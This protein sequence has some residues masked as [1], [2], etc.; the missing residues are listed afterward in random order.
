MHELTISFKFSYVILMF[1]KKMF[2]FLLVYFDLHLMSFFCFFHF[3]ILV[4][5]F[6]FFL[7]QLL[8]GNFPECV[9]FISLKLKIIPF[10][11][12]SIKFFTKANNVLL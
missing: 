8:F 7:F 10:F 2:D 5:Q 11:S 9:N 6:S 3:T 12:F 4:S 1:I